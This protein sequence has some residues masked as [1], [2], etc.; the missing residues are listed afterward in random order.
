M[1]LLG[2][3]FCALVAANTEKII[4]TAPA[5]LRIPQQHP[6]LSALQL[7]TLSPSQTTL[8][9][10]LERSIPKKDGKEH[11]FILADLIPAARYELRVCWAAT[12][13]TAFDMSEY[14]FDTVMNTPEL[15]TSLSKYSTTRMSKGIAPYDFASENQS[16]LFVRVLAASEFVSANKTLM[17]HPPPVYVDLILDNYLLGAIPQ[18]LVPTILYIILIAIAGYFVSRMYVRWLTDFG[19]IKKNN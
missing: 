12:T 8:R 13:P 1:K 3:L 6:T 16:I 10:F 19:S 18:S 15:I 14:T 2:L 7:D 5:A 9:T 4:F 11:W 17:T